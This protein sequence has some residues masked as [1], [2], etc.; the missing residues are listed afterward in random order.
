MKTATNPA[1]GADPDAVAA[2]YSVGYNA[3]LL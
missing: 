1:D 3:F 2:L